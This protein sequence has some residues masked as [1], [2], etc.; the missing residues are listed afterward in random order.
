MKKAII[1]FI[2]LCCWTFLALV[3]LYIVYDVTVL[4]RS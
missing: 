1:E 4:L 3:T 2:E